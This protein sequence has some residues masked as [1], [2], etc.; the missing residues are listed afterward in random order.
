MS[1]EQVVLAAAK[2]LYD[3]QNEPHFSWETAHPE[4]KAHWIKQARNTLGLLLPE[5]F[6]SPPTMWLAP[7]EASEDMVNAGGYALQ[8]HCSF[9]M[10]AARIAY[11]AARDAYLNR[12]GK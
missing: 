7:M 6:T 4:M 3:R 9:T 5:L 1:L 8:S 10:D 11:I 2:R 12:E